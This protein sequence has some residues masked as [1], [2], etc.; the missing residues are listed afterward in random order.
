MREKIIIIIQGNNF[1]FGSETIITNRRDLEK[2]ISGLEGFVHGNDSAKQ[3]DECLLKQPNGKSSTVSIIPGSPSKSASS[4]KLNIIAL[5]AG[6]TAIAVI[7]GFGVI[8]LLQSHSV[9]S[10]PSSFH[11]LASLIGTIGN[12]PHFWS[13]WLI[14]GSGCI[15]GSGLCG[16]AIAE[17][18]RKTNLKNTEASMHSSG[19]LKI[20]ANQLS[21]IPPKTKFLQTL[22]YDL[23]ILIKWFDEKCSENHNRISFH[24]MIKN[25]FQKN[26]ALLKAYENLPP[27]F[28]DDLSVYLN[29]II[30]LLQRDPTNIKMTLEVLAEVAVACPPT[31]YE[32]IKKQLT[33]L[34]HPNV[35]EIQLLIWIQEIKE[36]IIL[37]LAQGQFDSEWHALN[38]ARYH[39]GKE[40]GLNREGLKNDPY[41][42]KKIFKNFTKRFMIDIFKKNFTVER[43][44]AALEIKINKEYCDGFY[45]MLKKAVM[46]IGFNE[47]DANSYVA[48]NFYDEDENYNNKM[49]RKGIIMLLKTMGILT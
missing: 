48:E 4:V 32:G 22:N 30:Y 33:S 37:E 14:A 35:G 38:Y 44:I 49:N 26:P 13:L 34:Q 11:G 15:L 41:F 7:G 19:D 40:L 8:G 24:N 31:W 3:V 16:F 45:G 29:N 6:I 39:V 42:S 1:M 27:T 5:L 12:T 28:Y 17:L 10:L 18:T 46:E 9:I 47:G 36:E 2:F 20:N 43:L 25:I 23:G 21:R